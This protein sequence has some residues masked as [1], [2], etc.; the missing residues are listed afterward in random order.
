MVTLNYFGRYMGIEGFESKGQER[1][2]GVGVG[3]GGWWECMVIYGLYRY[4]P[5]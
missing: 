3:V 2:A 4:V 5:L 1:L